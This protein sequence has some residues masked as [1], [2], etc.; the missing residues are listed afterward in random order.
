MGRFLGK[1]EV[2]SLSSE[3]IENLT[4]KWESKSLPFLKKSVS[5]RQFTDEFFQGTNDSYIHFSRK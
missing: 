2:P 4:Q 1:Y 5:P 3:E